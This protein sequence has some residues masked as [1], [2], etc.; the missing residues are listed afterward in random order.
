MA[1]K[2]RK[3]RNIALAVLVAAIGAGL[4][5]WIT[6]GPTVEVKRT[7]SGILWRN[8]DNSF[9]QEVKVTVRGKMNHRTF[10]GDIAVEGTE[11][12]VTGVRADMENGHAYLDRAG[13]FDFSEAPYLAAVLQEGR[14]SSLVLFV[15]EVDS[16]SEE[17][18]QS[19][20]G[21]EDGLVI[22]APCTTREEA[23]A[24]FAQLRGKHPGLHPYLS[25]MDW[26]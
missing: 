7:C 20:F 25:D 3:V 9:C 12:N 11:L 22:S 2:N 14:F 26:A 5:W 17:E 19:H 21:G 10:W 18:M 13:H 15:G 1:A 6:V 16:V 4:A 8:H 24:L 23:L